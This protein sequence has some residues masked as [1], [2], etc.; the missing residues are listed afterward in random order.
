MACDSDR[1]DAINSWRSGFIRCRIREEPIGSHQLLARDAKWVISSDD[2]EDKDGEEEEE[3]GL[4][5]WLRTQ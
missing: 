5:E 2:T 4:V 1:H 3:E